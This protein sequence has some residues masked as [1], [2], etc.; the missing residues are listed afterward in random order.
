MFHVLEARS[1][2]FT[3]RFEIEEEASFILSAI[4]NGFFSTL[5]LAMDG[6]AKRTDVKNFKNSHPLFYARANKGGL[7][8]TTVHVKHIKPDHSGYI[9]PKGDS[10][11]FNFKE[12]PKIVKEN[13]DSEDGINFNMG[14]YFYLEINTDHKRI[15]EI[16][17]KHYDELKQFI[18]SIKS[19]IR[20]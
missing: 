17:D 13:Q 2:S 3:D 12:L 19:L 10:I 14:K 9:P 7:R 1:I 8:N 6:G 18:K 20:C 15:I 16:M 11:N 5:E 4:L